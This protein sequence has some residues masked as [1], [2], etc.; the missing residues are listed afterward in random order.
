MV[1]LALEPFAGTLPACP[2]RSKQLAR[3]GLQHRVEA[4]HAGSVVGQ[5]LTLQNPSTTQGY[6]YLHKLLFFP[7]AAPEQRWQA[8]YDT[9]PQCLG[10]QSFPQPAPP[11]L[12]Q[13]Q[14]REALLQGPPLDATTAVQQRGCRDTD[15]AEPDCTNCGVVAWT[16]VCRQLAQDTTGPRPYRPADRRALASIVAAVTMGPVAAWLARLLPQVPCQDA[17]PCQR[18]ATSAT[19]APLRAE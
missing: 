4:A 10:A 14:G 13:G 12:P 11:A 16:A 5:W 15:R 6:W 17:G 1:D 19:T 18:A 3:L 9:H 7:R 2:C 8:P